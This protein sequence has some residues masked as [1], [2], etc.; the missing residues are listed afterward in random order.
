MFKIR[1]LYAH[2]AADDEYSKEVEIVLGML[3]A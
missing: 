3:R 2:L 1:N